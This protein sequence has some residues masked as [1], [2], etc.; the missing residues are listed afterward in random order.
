MQYYK[1][2]KELNFSRNNKKYALFNLES[3]I[4]TL[5][6]NIAMKEKSDMYKDLDSSECIKLF[7][8]EEAYTTL[9]LCI[10]RDYTYKNNNKYYIYLRLDKTFKHAIYESQKIDYYGNLELFEVQDRVLD[11]VLENIIENNLTT[12]HSHR[13][14]GSC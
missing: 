3:K 10:D 4:Q 8:Y 2:I 14:A 6:S 13:L 5:I 9:Y 1:N 11:L 7:F 12:L